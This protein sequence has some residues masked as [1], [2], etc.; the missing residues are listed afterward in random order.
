MRQVRAEI[1]IRQ[2]VK[3]EMLFTPRLYMFNGEQGLTLKA[4]T[5]DAVEMFGLYADLMYCAAL[6]L[7]TLQGKGKEDAPF[8][9]VDF[10]EFAAAN[11]R[12]FGK[13]VKIALEALTG[14]SME[15]IVGKVTKGAET[16][17]NA[18]KSKKKV[19]TCRLMERLRRFLLGD[20][21]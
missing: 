16:P 9:R 18:A 3:V 11:P 5:S 10:H 17:E 2:G 21:D 19:T 7:W 13:V 6:N 15:A 8:E 12:A 1:E 14:K 4:N 20:V